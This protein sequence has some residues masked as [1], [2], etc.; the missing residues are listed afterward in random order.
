MRGWSFFL[1]GIRDAATDLL[2]D[3]IGGTQRERI[4]GAIKESENWPR[5]EPHT[6]GYIFTLMMIDALLQMPGEDDNES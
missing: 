4:A 3:E 5:A 6:K 2:T 1:E